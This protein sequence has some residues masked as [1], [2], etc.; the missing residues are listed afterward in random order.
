[1]NYMIRACKLY[2]GKIGTQDNYERL[3][4][5]AEK[6]T[7][8]ANWLDEHPGEQI[9]T[10]GT[11]TCHLCMEY[12]DAKCVDCPIYETTGQ[13]GCSNTP[14]EY[15]TMYRLTCG[16]FICRDATAARRE[17]EFL[18]A[19]RDGTRLYYCSKHATWWA[20]NHCPEC[21]ETDDTVWEDHWEP[22]GV[23]E[24]IGPPR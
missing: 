4:L 3:T 24:Y 8:V 9:D 18:I 11:Q 17:A 13:S 21:G 20:G 15:A 7:T 10:G 23:V 16:T 19:L 6:W 2:C 12:A 14:W 5:G 22:L 1:M